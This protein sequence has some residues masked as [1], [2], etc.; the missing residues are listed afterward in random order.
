MEGVLPLRLALPDAGPLCCVHGDGDRLP[1]GPPLLHLRLLH[2]QGPAHA[3]PAPDH[4]Q[5]GPALW[6]HPVLR[7]LLL[8]RD[9]LPGRLLPPREHLLL[10]LLLPLQLLL[11]RHPHGS[12]LLQHRQDLQRLLGAQGHQGYQ[13]GHVKLVYRNGGIFE[14]GGGGGR[15]GVIK[16]CIKRNGHCIG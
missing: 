13:E 2:R 16:A 9:H 12:H 7:H 6:R 8:Q 10:G 11:D 4:H 3:P 14:G 5:P 1:L 15:G